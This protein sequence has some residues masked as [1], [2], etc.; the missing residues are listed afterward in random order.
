VCRRTRLCTFAEKGTSTRAQEHK[1]ILFH[2]TLPHHFVFFRP[3]YEVLRRDPR[4]TVWCAADRLGWNFSRNVFDVFDVPKAH[5]I[6]CA[7]ALKKDY[8]LSI[9]PFYPKVDYGHRAALKLQIFHGVAITNCF[10]KPA[11][12]DFDKSFMVGP[13]MVKRF[14]QK[15]VLAADDPRIEMIGMPKVDRLVDGTYDR[16]AI[17]AELQV[18]P[19]LPTVLYAPS[20]SYSSLATDGLEVI[21]RIR[22]KPVNL[23]IKLHDKSRDRKR[24]LKIWLRQVDR[25]KQRSTR[26]LDWQE[27]VKKQESGNTR[28]IEGFDITPYLFVSD[29][30]I[31]DFSSA[32]NEFLLMD[33]PIIFL[34]TPDK[35]ERVKD[36]WDIEVWGQR[37]GTKVHTM[38]ELDEGLEDAIAQ[39][40]RMSAIRRAA[41]RDIF[42]KPGTATHRAVL[43]IYEYVQLDPPE[44]VKATHRD[45]D[46]GV[47]AP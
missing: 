6:S 46:A 41:A 40:E 45:V 11:I 14:V 22:R 43:K 13:Y 7:K 21:R 18:N 31:S 12:L 4:I 16:E 1:H 35:Y 30:L 5:V 47:F 38:A 26:V 20:G 3:V 44:E 8:D 36:R 23:L 33:R 32:A 9:S 27:Q 37:V 28:V 25:R 17:R 29:I 15:G 19:E 10:L 24:N 42:Y 39:P 34:D 2:I